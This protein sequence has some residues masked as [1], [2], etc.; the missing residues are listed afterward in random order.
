[1]KIQHGKNFL[2]RNS[3]SFATKQQNVHWRNHQ[4]RLGFEWLVLEYY[5]IVAQQ[6]KVEKKRHAAASW[7]GKFCGWN[8]INIVCN[9]KIHW[10]LV[11]DSPL[12]NYSIL[13]IWDVKVFWLSWALFIVDESFFSVGWTASQGRQRRYWRWCGSGGHNPWLSCADWSHRAQLVLGFHPSSWAR[14]FCG[15]LQSSLK[16]D[17][18]VESLHEALRTLPLQ[19][20]CRETSLLQTPNR[21]QSGWEQLED[22]GRHWQQ[23]NIAPVWRR[24]SG[25]WPG[26]SWTNV[27]TQDVVSMGEVCL[28]QTTA[29]NKRHQLKSK[30]FQFRKVAQTGWGARSLWSTSPARKGT[31]LGEAFPLPPQRK[32]TSLGR[33]LTV[34]WLGHFVNLTDLVFLDLGRPQS[35]NGFLVFCL[36]TQTVENSSVVGFAWPGSSILFGVPH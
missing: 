19:P 24:I 34:C 31:R 8:N 1:M 10:I 9:S 33:A 27:G 11:K 15:P 29:R 20:H 2:K 18:Q 17:S 26:R 25:K 22:S 16:E 36:A 32:W 12:Y 7:N 3:I 4:Q 6:S 23:V 30:Y 13:S 14:V 35:W 21:Q 28:T 5:R